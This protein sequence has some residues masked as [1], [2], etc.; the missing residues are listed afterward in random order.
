LYEVKQG[1]TETPTELLDRLPSAVQKFTTMDPT[2]DEARQ[3]L[4]SPFL[5]QST[6]DIRRKL[7]KLKEPDI[8]NLENLAEEVWRVYHNR[9]EEARKKMVRVIALATVAA[10]SQQNEEV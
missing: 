8:R 7:Q 1:Q 6:N 3:Q 10:L 5:R 9:D 4:V 2:S